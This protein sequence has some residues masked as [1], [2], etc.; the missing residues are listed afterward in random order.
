[1][2]LKSFITTIKVKWRKYKLQEE[3]LEQ[4][5]IVEYCNKR[6][7][8]IFSVPNGIN[9]KSKV[10]RTIFKA[11]GLSSGVPDL[12][13]PIVNDEYGGLFIE[14]K[15][16]TGGRVSPSQKQWIAKLNS[17]GY[18]AIVCNGADVA[19]REIEEYIII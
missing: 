2:T 15:T 10:S 17:L 5:A 16:V 11:M 18:R 7:I 14:L 9:I 13:I 3:Q 19:I 4:I 1:M 6:E 8:P 12:M